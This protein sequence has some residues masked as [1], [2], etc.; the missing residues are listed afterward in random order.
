MICVAALILFALLGIF[1]V[2][3]RKLAKEAWVCVTRRVTLRPC[4]TDFQTKVK[5]LVVGK[6]I[7]KNEKVASFVSRHFK[8]LAWVVVIL[9]IASTV[10]LGYATYNW[11]RYQTCD[12]WT[13]NCPVGA[14]A[15][16]NTDAG[17]F[18]GGLQR[19]FGVNSKTNI[20]SVAGPEQS[21]KINIVEFADYQCPACAMQYKVIDEFLKKHSGKVNFVFRNVII[22]GHTGSPYAAQ[23]AEAARK[24]NKFMEMYG[25]LFSRQKEWSSKGYYESIFE[26]YAKELGL[27]MEKFKA[28]RDSQEVKDKITADIAEAEKLGVQGTPTLF[29]NGTMHF[30]FV[31][32]AELEE[33]VK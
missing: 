17:S 3:Y 31:E 10:Y 13:N 33:A 7:G 11:V 28:D 16:V 21:G 8:G 9:S 22:P 2:T 5:G 6:L 20:S 15:C 25:L 26:G 29:I 1:S 14:K 4:E 12:P 30:G 32:L 18:W 27:D 24:Q 19:L 23:A